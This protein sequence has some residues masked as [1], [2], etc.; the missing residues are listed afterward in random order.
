LPI[1]LKH[2]GKRRT[3]DRERFEEGFEAI[4]LSVIVQELR[5][6][7]GMTQEQLAKNSVQQ[8]HI[9]HELRIMLPKS[10]FPH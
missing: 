3:V 4:K 2:Y 8:K 9:S 1:N 5:K 10:G 6:E 7:N